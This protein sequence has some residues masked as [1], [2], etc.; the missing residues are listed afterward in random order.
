MPDIKDS[1]GEGAKNNIHDV[2]LVQAMLRIVKNAKNAP[3]LVSNYDGIYG[4]DTK[5]AIIAF[6][7]DQK[8][9]AQSN[10]AG[11]SPAG[12]EKQ[13][14]IG[15]DSATFKRLVSVLPAT[16]KEITI[17]EN[18]KTV[19]IGAPEDDAQGSEG[20][21]SA[22]MELEA[23]FRGK[24][25]LL[26]QQVYKDHKIAL[27]L[28][29]SGGRRT[30]AQQAALNP[31]TTKA[32]PGESNHN[33]GRAVDIGFKNL[34][35]LAGDGSIVKDD[36]WLNKLTK[37]S[38]KKATA[39]WV[40]RNAIA[41][42][43]PPGLFSIGMWDAI[44]LQSYKQGL[45]SVA[46]SLADLLN[47]IGK[48]KWGAQPA[49]PN[50]Y[51]TDLGFGGT[52]FTGGTAKQIWA[53]QATVTKAMIAQART[54]ALKKAAMKAGPNSK[55]FKQFKPVKEIDIKQ[56]EVTTLQKALKTDFEQAD[57]HWQK[58]KPSP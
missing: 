50:Q 21:I 12:L 18:T 38:E 4:K 11:K 29:P 9:A 53:G 58:W 56:D 5:S 55:E 30:F 44:H 46:R 40:A 15:K 32:G 51:Q 19:Y 13:G 25:V 42:K 45:V 23:T 28:T 22:N 3:Y 41:E 27:C 47:T 37:V 26:V 57:Q 52:L 54:D 17:I 1:V 24:V 31:A 35:W 39:F 48:L 34:E 33:F 43:G 10:P 16:H 2:A 6:Q 8:L 20:A 7:T 49:K 14:F 36:Y